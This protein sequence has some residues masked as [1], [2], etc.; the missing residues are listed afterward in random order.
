MFGRRWA[1]KWATTKSVRLP[2]KFQPL[3]LAFFHTRL[4]ERGS[5]PQ[6]SHRECDPRCAM[7]PCPSGH[8]P[9][10]HDRPVIAKIHNRFKADVVLAILLDD[11]WTD[12]R[13]R[14][15]F[16]DV[17]L[18]FPKRA[19]MSCHRHALVGQI[20]ECLSSWTAGCMSSRMTFSA[21]LTTVYFLPSL[22][23]TKFFGRPCDF[24]LAASS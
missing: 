6:S 13:Q 16:A 17:L 20:V 8:A 22:R 18:G 23:T 5:Y 1:T 12:P 10:H 4:L 2:R 9:A 7:A 19:A 14:Q 21:S 15:Q 24:M 3:L 11:L